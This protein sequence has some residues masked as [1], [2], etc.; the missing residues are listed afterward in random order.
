MKAARKKVILTILT[1][2]LLMAA[3]C[4]NNKP[5][6]KKPEQA[7][8]VED[9]KI[10]KAKDLNIEQIHGIGY[11]GNDP[12]LYL[13][14]DKGLKMYKESQWFETT[15]NHH[16]YSGFQAIENGFIASGKPE[17][18]SG[19]KNP[20]GIVQ[21]EDKGETIKKLAFYGNNNFYFM[22]ASY[23]GEAI[24]VIN[25]QENGDL[26]LGVN[27]STDHGKGWNASKLKDFNADSLGMMA[28]HPKNGNILAM[29][30]RSGIYYSEDN[31][32]TMKL[33]TNPFM[34]TSLTF[35]GDVLLFSSV[36]NEK[37]LLKTINPK[38][39]EQTNLAIPFLDYQN[40]ITFLAVNPKDTK[41]IAFTTYNNDLFESKDSGTHWSNLMTNGKTELE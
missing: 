1:G 21:S 29:S 12:A 4:T 3:G 6:T 27:Y 23:S 18:N 9:F 24:Y 14:A 20:L 19:L 2:M 25:Q 32:N 34:V 28:V 41:Q 33:I 40:P 39:G 5:E 30:T 26:E 10:V 15:T 8:N 13:A 17:K 38:S 22:A 35:M 7:V 36:E 11:P 16:N 31:G 37:I